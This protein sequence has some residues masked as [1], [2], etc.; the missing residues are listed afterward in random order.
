MTLARETLKVS[1]PD[2]VRGKRG[3]EIRGIFWVEEKPETS[4]FAIRLSSAVDTLI[5]ELDSNKLSPVLL[6]TMENALG[7]NPSFHGA[8]DIPGSSRSFAEWDVSGV[9]VSDLKSKIGKAFGDEWQNAIEQLVKAQS[10]VKDTS[11]L[12]IELDIPRSCCCGGRT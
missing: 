6:S 7:A 8:R 4:S 1:Q 12:R 3:P 11:G 2:L 9:N 5:L 10:T